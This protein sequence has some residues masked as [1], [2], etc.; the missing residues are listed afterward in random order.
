MYMQKKRKFS[1]GEYRHMYFSQCP[2][3]RLFTET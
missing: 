3:Y 1:C 2:T